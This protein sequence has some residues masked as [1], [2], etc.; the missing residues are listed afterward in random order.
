MSSGFVLFLESLSMS[1]PIPA[2]FFAGFYFS[3]YFV[4][5][6]VA[7]LFSGLFVRFCF[8]CFAVRSLRTLSSD[9]C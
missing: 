8:I 5:L 2:A 1:V 7:T 3:E 9:F 4:L 6:T